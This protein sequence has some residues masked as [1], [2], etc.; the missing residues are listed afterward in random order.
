[1]K[2]LVMLSLMFLG[3]FFVAP[4]WS[5]HMAEGI[6]SDEVWLRVD[7]QLESSNSLHNINMESV[8]DSMV[9]EIDPNGNEVLASEYTVLTEDV[10]EYMEAFDIVMD[11]MESEM[12]RIPSGDRNSEDTASLK[13]IL[14]VIPVT[15]ID[16]DW[17]TI[18]VYEPIGSGESQDGDG[19]DT[20][21]SGSG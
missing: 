13:A 10:D 21:P 18:Y 9:M 14:V 4:V 8:L 7:E 11:Q 20:P 12:Q 3:I 17:T 1:M 5:H 19:I 16:P 15:Q 2:R 6:V